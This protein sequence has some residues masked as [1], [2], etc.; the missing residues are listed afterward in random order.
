MNLK[1]KKKSIA[2]AMGVSRKRVVFNPESLEDIQKAITKNDLRSLVSQG[3]IAIAQKKGISSSRKKIIKKQKRKGRRSGHG[4]RKGTRNARLDSKRNWINSIRL[5]R[6]YLKMLRQ[7]NYIGGKD[8]RD[9]YRKCSGG[10]FRS[11]R[12]IRLYLEE[13]EILRVE[14]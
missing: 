6:E 3:A 9:L 11:K 7:K 4:S 1:N 10:F 5:Q 2:S 12:H 14:K 8:Y 13:K